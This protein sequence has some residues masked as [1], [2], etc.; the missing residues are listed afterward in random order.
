MNPVLV[1]SILVGYFSLLITISYFTSRGAKK[2]SFYTGD[3]SSPWYVVSFGMIGAS[4]SGVTFLSIPGTIAAKGFSYM[5]MVLGYTIG[6]LIIAKVLLPLYYKYKLV[7][8]YSFLGQRF[9]ENSQMTGSFFFLISRVVGASLRLFLVAL[10]LDKAIFQ[11]YDIPFWLSVAVTI[12]LIWI[13]TFRGG[14]KTVVW[15]DLLQTAFM[16]GAVILT[17]IIIYSSVNTEEQSWAT[18]LGQSGYTK[19]FHWSGEFSFW[20]LFLSGIFITVVMTGL[21]QDMMQKNLTVGTLK[22]SQKNMYWLSVNIVVINLVFLFLG[23]MLFIYAEQSGILLPE[24]KDMVFAELALYH[25]PLSVRV[26]FVLGTVAAAY[27]SADSALTSLTTSFSIDFLEFNGV[28]VTKQKRTFVHVGFSVLLFI[29]IL[30]V[31]AFATESIV[32]LLFKLAGI[33]YGPLLGIFMLGIFSKVNLKDTLV[34]Y[35]CGLAA[36]A[37]IM[38]YLFS[39]SW[40]GYKFG[41]EISLI[42]TSVTIIGLL[43][44]QNK[45]QPIKSRL[46]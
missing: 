7:S 6:Y 1:I 9:G 18:L 35:V 33:T 10:V 20:K 14:I 25:L 4:L 19:V 16:L 3:K 27:S 21:D 5:Q 8:I 43:L 31:K 41:L 23:A 15:T 34:P 12:L 46:D 13:Y 17:I 28:N 29:V 36:I 45:K 30:I 26:L 40:F 37:S 2:D 22:D 32:W 11:F 44:I 38:L 42:S 24:R 39:E